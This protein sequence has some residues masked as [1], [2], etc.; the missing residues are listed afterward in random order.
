MNPVDA[1]GGIGRKYHA[2]QTMIFSPRHLRPSGAQHLIIMNARRAYIAAKFFCLLFLTGCGGQLYKVA[3]L[4]A[5]PPEL[6]NSGSNELK[7]G[8]VLID[9]DDSFDR[10][11]ANLPLAG[12]IAVEV[13]LANHSAGTI[14]AGALKFELSDGSGARLRQISPKKALDR[15]MKFYGN[16]IYTIESRRRTRQDYQDVSLPVGAAIAPGEERRGIL[17]F[18]DKRKVKDLSGLK[19]TIKGAPAPLSVDL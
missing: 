16:S 12:V 10:F 19:L 15:V 18:E 9:S 6:S 8:A 2:W 5:N 17:F 1:G 4:P 7:I 14:G 11:E 3:P 13:R